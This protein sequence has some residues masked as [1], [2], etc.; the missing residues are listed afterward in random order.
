[1]VQGS[2]FVIQR[3]LGFRIWD[4][5]WSRVRALGFIGTYLEGRGNLVSIH[6]TPISPIVTSIITVIN[7]LTK[8][9]G[10]SK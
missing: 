6:I 3:G 7:L 1:M 9:P 5:K 2:G 4:L 8:S 10:P